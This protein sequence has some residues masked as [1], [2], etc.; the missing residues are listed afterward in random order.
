CGIY[1][2]A[3]DGRSG[4]TAIS[5]V[6]DYPFGLRCHLRYTIADFDS[7][8]VRHASE[9]ADG[10]EARLALPPQRERFRCDAKHLRM[11]SALVATPSDHDAQLHHTDILCERLALHGHSERFHAGSGYRPTRWN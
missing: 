10:G 8:D 1:P 5:R 7:H 9:A 11:G 4:W 3:T 2:S 6:R